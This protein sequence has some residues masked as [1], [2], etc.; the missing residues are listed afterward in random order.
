M[1]PGMNPRVS[2]SIR[3]ETERK[4]KEE[5]SQTSVQSDELQNTI[6]M[7]K[8]VYYF[9]AFRL[10]VPIKNLLGRYMRLLYLAT[11]EVAG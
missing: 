7:Y 10:Y 11:K 6:Q 1:R 2:G 5:S 9:A 8:C 3:S 4:E